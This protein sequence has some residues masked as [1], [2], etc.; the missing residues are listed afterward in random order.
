MKFW[1][2]SREGNNMISPEFFLNSLRQKGIDFFCGVPD[3]LLKNFCACIDDHVDKNSNIITANEGNAIALAAGYHLATGK[4]GLVYMQNSGIGNSINPL[5]SLTDPEVYKIPILLVI[6]WRGEP[7]V[8]DEPQHVK[9]G[10]ISTKQLEILEIPYIILD[11]QS[12]LDEILS[13]AFDELEKK[14]SPV[15]I[16]VKAETFSVYKSSK[17]NPFDYPLFREEALRIILNL[18]GSKDLFISTTGKTSRELYEL[19]IERNEAQK[20]FLTVGAMGHTSSI[21]LGVALGRPE[22]RV[23]CIDGDGSMLMHMGALPVIGDIKPPNLIHVIIN[24]ASHESVGGQPTVAGT[25][26]FRSLALSC[27]YKSC[28]S[29]YDADTLNNAWS[30]IEKISGPVML[31]IRVKQGSRD[32]LSRPSGAPVENKKNFMDHINAG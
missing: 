1:N 26:N 16:L 10:R 18:S 28:F 29:A 17:T 25:I 7:G 15:A 13:T 24:N 2:L 9:Q 19:R 4:T 21:A 32:N 14:K 22:K 31:E 20:D 3:S 8:K 6:G 11:F 5:T 12:D 23:I 27:G 30:E